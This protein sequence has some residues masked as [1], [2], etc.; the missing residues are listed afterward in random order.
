L[1]PIRYGPYGAIR[2]QPAVPDD[3]LFVTLSGETI[4]NNAPLWRCNACNT[5]SGNL[6]DP[7]EAAEYL[8]HVNHIDDASVAGAFAG[9]LLLQAI[10][11]QAHEV[12]W[13]PPWVYFVINATAH[14]MEPYPRLCQEQIV[15]FFTPVAPQYQVTIESVEICFTLSFYTKEELRCLLLTITSY[16]NNEQVQLPRRSRYPT[17][18]ACGFP[19]RTPLA[20]QCFECG[21][22]WHDSNSPRTNPA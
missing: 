1:A 3:V 5:T 7:L 20:K 8:E 18:P 6:D 16:T 2:R 14:L 17:C 10:A 4:R 12:K 21:L 22:D 15:R 13:E 11:E 9:E 19:L